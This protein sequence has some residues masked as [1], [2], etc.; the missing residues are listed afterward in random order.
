MCCFEYS[1]ASRVV[2]ICTRCNTNTT[3]KRWGT[4]EENGVGKFADFTPKALNEIKDMGVSH[5]WYT[6]VLHHAMAEDYTQF[7]I[8]LDDPDVIKG[9]AG[10]PYAIKDYYS[11]N[12]D[13]AN[14]PA[15]RIEEFEALIKRSHAAGLK[16]IID[17][18][19]NH[20]ARN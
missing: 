10:S 2:D 4:I 6:G 9:R 19:P 15:K 12:P 5:I 14:N 18:V 7:G 11:V 17:I 16:V 1:K 13:L 20:V 8:S 3:N